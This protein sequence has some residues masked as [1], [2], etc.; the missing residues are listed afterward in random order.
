MTSINQ[1]W[2]WVIGLA[3]ALS[4]AS[5]RGQ[6]AVQKFVI[7]PT[8]PYV[9]LKFDHIGKREPLNRH[10]PDT[11]LWLRVE[12]NCRVPITVQVF[13]PETG[14]PG[15]GLFDE[16]IPVNPCAPP[17]GCPLRPNE[18]LPKAPE[19]PKGYSAPEILNT[20]NIE[21]GHDLLFSVPI[22]HVGPSWYLQ[23]EFFLGSEYGYGPRS[24]L[25]FAWGDIPEKFRR[26]IQP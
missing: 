10:E 19:L 3:L 4:A 24:L 9:Y 17:M 7:D 2:C 21:P 23:V 1:I 14:D 20:E 8:R 13:D 26:K 11:G 25:D 16:V 15:V 5:L 6:D 22:N 18:S 12:N